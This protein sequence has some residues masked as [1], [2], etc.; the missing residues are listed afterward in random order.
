MTSLAVATALAEG[1][2]AK[3]APM[4][5]TKTSP[6]TGVKP[7]GSLAVRKANIKP[8][9]SGETGSTPL[10]HAHAVRPGDDRCVR[11]PN[12]QTVLHHACNAVESLGERLRIGDAFEC[13]IENPVPS[14]RDESVAVLGAPQQ[15]GPGAADRRGRR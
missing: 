9:S 7:Q 6:K 3:A 2:W 5:R 15:R 14:V 13:G 1:C 11:E 10:D 8:S 4:L 12:E